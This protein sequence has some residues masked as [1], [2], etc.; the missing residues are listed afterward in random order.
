MKSDFMPTTGGSLFRLPLLFVRYLRGKAVVKGFR[1]P[2]ILPAGGFRQPGANFLLS[3]AV[4]SLRFLPS[5]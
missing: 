2:E 1:L 4:L 5:A 3:R